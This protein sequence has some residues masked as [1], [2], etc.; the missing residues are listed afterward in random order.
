M[1]VNETV[2]II[3]VH[4]GTVPPLE[5]NPSVGDIV[6]CPYD[7]S[8]YR[9]VVEEVKDSGHVRVRFV[10]Y[11]DEKTVD[12]FELRSIDDTIAG[13]SIISSNKSC[14]HVVQIIM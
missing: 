7:D 8:Y 11:G 9:A 14:R 5:D 12:A 1:N 10:D 2:Y 6:L 4:F 13:V 3:F